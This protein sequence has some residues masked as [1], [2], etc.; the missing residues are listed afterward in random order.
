MTEN[1]TLLATMAG[2][3]LQ[4]AVLHSL[5]NSDPAEVVRAEK[6]HADGKLYPR[7]TIT[8]P[9]GAGAMRIELVLCHPDTDEPIVRMF[10][11]EATAEGP[12]WPH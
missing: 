7:L 3:L 10:E 11:G 9:H 2:K 8:T 1:D 4:M 5:T 6:L 12:A